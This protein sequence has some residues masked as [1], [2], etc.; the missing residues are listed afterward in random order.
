MKNNL[1]KNKKI[2][3]VAK[4]I[5]PNHLASFLSCK[6]EMEMESRMGIEELQKK[7]DDIICFKNKKC[8]SPKKRSVKSIKKGG[9]RSSKKRMSSKKIKSGRRHSIKKIAKRSPIK[10]R[11]VYKK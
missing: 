2:L 10:R 8:R 3:S 5:L 7:I 6:S 1:I 4:K 9:R 11:S